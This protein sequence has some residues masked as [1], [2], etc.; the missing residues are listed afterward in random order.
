MRFVKADKIIAWRNR[1]ERQGHSF[2]RTLMKIRYGFFCLLFGFSAQ[3]ALTVD[4][5]LAFE[6]GADAPIKLE[7]KTG[8][9]TR[10]VVKVLPDV[11]PGA[12]IL[13]F[14]GVETNAYYLFLS[15]PGYAAR[16][17][18]VHIQNDTVSLIPSDTDITLYRKRY[19]VIRYAVNTAGNRQLQ[20]AD[21]EEGRC[22]ASHWGMVPHFGGD[23][24]VWQRQ[25]KSGFFGTEPWLEFHRIMSS[26]GFAAAPEGASFES[27]NEAP[28]D[29]QYKTESVRATKGLLL[30]C[31]VYGNRPQEKCCGKILVEDITET[32][33]PG[34]RVIKSAYDE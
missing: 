15:S 14:S 17:V 27:M 19:V 12:V 22:A 6:D 10:E 23:W 7:L 26:F 1:C 24:Q 16:W 29:D 11:R 5:R 32:P 21:V 20:G 4:V 3:A 34:V 31:R 9:T 18:A 28:G 13:D 2:G 8:P 25:S 30:Y 33:P